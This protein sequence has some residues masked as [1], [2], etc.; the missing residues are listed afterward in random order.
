MSITKEKPPPLPPTARDAG[1]GARLW[2]HVAVAALAMVATLPGRTHGLGLFTEPIRHTFGL[3]TE[4]YGFL[5]MWATLLGALF[6]LPCGWLVD[7]VGTRAVLTGVMLALGGVVVGMSQ[8]R[9]DL[10]VHWTFALPWAGTMTVV[11]LLDLFL[12]VLLTRG[13]G[14]S[15]LSVASLALIGRTASRRTGLAMGVYAVLTSAG[16]LGAF[17][18]LREVVLR[19]PGLPVIGANTVGLLAS[20]GGAGGPLLAASALFPGR[21]HYLSEWRAEWAGI[22]IAVLAA[23][24]LSAFLV[25]NRLLDADPASHDGAAGAPAETSLTLGQALRSPSFWTFGLAV[26][27]FGMVSAGTSLFNETILGDLR[28]DRRVFLNVTLV[29]IPVGLASNLLG[30]WLAVRRSLS[31]LLAVAMVALGAALLAFPHVRSEWQAYLYAA[32]LAASGG[33]ITV[34]FFTVWRR[35]FGPAHLGAV[36]GAAQ[37][38]TVLFSA[39]GPQLFGSAKA[40]LGTYLPLFPYLAAASLLLALATALAGL[41]KRSSEA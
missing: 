11:L 31:G 30:G 26:S 3:D 37:M 15:A 10:W 12:F 20:P 9:G 23:G 6:C 8:M 25:R 1:G 38:L 14:Q 21:Q 33:V 41:P 40:R 16:F 35:G 13:L 5:N 32:V 27:F 39:L 29:G 18:V 17:A 28:F 24:V 7:R 36:Q 4:S 34:C 19:E 2:V 22:G